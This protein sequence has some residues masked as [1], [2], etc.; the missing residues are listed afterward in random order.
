MAQEK[1][2]DWAKTTHRYWYLHHLHHK[3]KHKW[4]DAKDFYRSYG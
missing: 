2:E 1:P 3:I 4:L